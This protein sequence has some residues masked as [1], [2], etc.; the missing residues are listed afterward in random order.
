MKNYKIT[1]RY[2]VVAG[3]ILLAPVFGQQG[4]SR[5]ISINTNANTLQAGSGYTFS[6]AGTT[7]VSG[8]NGNGTFLA[9][10]SLASAS[11]LTASDPIPAFASISYPNGDTLFARLNLPAGY[12][13]SS[14]GQPSTSNATMTILGGTGAFAN[15]TGTFNTLPLAVAITGPNT[16]TI[17]T[18]GNAT[19]A[20]PSF[21]SQGSLAFAG[22]MGHLASGGGWKTT[23]TA[24]NSG[25]TPAQVELRFYD[26]TGN[27]L[28][29]PVTYPQNN[30]QPSNSTTVSQTLAPGAYL[31]LESQATT[32]NPLTGSAQLWTDGQVSAYII[33]TYVPTGQEAAVPLLTTSASAYALPFD[34]TSG[35][36]NGV[37]ISNV[38]GTS[39]NVPISIKD[40]M[41]ATIANTNITLAPYGHSSFV[42]TERYS[43]AAGRRGVIEFTTP[44]GG[45]ISPIGIRA[46]TG[47]AYTTIP[48]IPLMR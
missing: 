10:G 19:I 27:P 18:Q 24:V 43:V 9:T 7:T 35:L 25:T 12:V 29:L 14:L 1:A 44:Q 36:N 45:Q 3:L 46:A 33:F 13:V 37:A 22:S 39:V 16:A 11:G 34:N 20:T 21:R 4:T 8:V 28:S 15:S 23:I 17:S 42:I 40:E 26:D 6:L 48:A 5:T 38:T 2:F 31:V 41:G 32:Q 30:T 47:G